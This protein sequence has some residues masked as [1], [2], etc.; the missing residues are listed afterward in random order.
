MRDELRRKFEAM[1]ARAAEEDASDQEEFGSGNGRIL[2]ENLA[3]TRRRIQEVPAAIQELE[4][5]T[6][7]GEPTPQHNPLTAQA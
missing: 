6:P 7:A 2:P 4:R 1:E 3:D 5:V